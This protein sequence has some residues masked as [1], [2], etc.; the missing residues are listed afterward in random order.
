VRLISLV[1]VVTLFASFANGQTKWQSLTSRE[2]GFTVSFPGKPHSEF[3]SLKVDNGVM[4]YRSYEY[5]A[6]KNYVLGVTCNPIT[7]EGSQNPDAL[8]DSARDAA[9]EKLH[10]T[11]GREMRLKVQGHIARLVEL[12]G[13]G[14]WGYGELVVANG[15]Y[16]QV[17][18][19]VQSKAYR[20]RAKQFLKSFRLLEEPPQK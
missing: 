11:K 5:D 15:N 3:K 17:L 6:N 19:V 4:E 2:C 16:Y 9:I 7:G 10:A 1:A 20:G 12:S 14:F 13:D 18:A 8:I